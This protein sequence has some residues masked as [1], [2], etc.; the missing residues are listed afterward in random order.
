MLMPIELKAEQFTLVRILFKEIIYY[1]N[2]DK[3]LYH[4][5]N[6]FIFKVCRTYIKIFS[7][8]V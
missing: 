2:I 5:G 6:S 4:L 7:K 1:A 8:M 3:F